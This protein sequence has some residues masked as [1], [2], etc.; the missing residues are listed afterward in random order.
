MKRSDEL[1]V[2]SR[3]TFVALTGAG[4]LGLVV[5]CGSGSSSDVDAAQASIDAP[6]GSGACSVTGVDVGA[7]ST[8]TMGVP[9]LTKRLVVVQDASGFYAMSAACTHQ[10]QLVCIG[11]TTSCISTGT[12]LY[13]TRHG[14][15][16]S[17]TGLV[18]RGPA[19]TPLPHY[20]MCTLANGNLGVLTTMTVS[21]TTR[22]QP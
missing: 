16:F 19:N 15:A 21:S 7:P 13:C 10:G 12:D 17:F 1:V 22:Y 4:G 20:A 3:R 18:V 6:S 9:V 11:T 14:A 8:Y 5:A 2:I